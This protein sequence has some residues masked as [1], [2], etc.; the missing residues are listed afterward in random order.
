LNA[1][2]VYFNDALKFFMADLSLVQADRDDD[3]HEG[4]SKAEAKSQTQ[5][6]FHISEHG[7]F[8]GL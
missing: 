3:N 7:N 1:D 4:D 6:D 2:I 5:S 8:P